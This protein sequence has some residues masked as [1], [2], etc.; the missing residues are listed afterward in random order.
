MMRPLIIIRQTS[1][2]DN[3]YTSDK[4]RKKKSIV[5]SN[6]NILFAV[7]IGT[8]AGAQGYDLAT[9]SERA[10]SHGGGNGG[11]R[12]FISGARDFSARRG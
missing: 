1:N 11:G 12:S 3:Y 2:N 5:C 8:N 6:L 4:E 9:L 10:F 7:V